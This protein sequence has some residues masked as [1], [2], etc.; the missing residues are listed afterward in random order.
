MPWGK[1]SLEFRLGWETGGEGVPRYAGQEQKRHAHLMK[2]SLSAWEEGDQWQSRVPP[3]SL[4][5][6]LISALLPSP[7]RVFPVGKDA[8]RNHF[9]H[10]WDTPRETVLVCLVSLLGNETLHTLQG[11]GETLK[12]GWWGIN[13]WR[14]KEEVLHKALILFKI[15]NQWLFYMCCSFKGP[16]LLKR[17]WRASFL[18]FLLYKPFL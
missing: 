4:W 17:H 5:F 3:S 6:C 18:H 8:H 16:Y 1:D 9:C 2:L 11:S 13:S 7:Q 12:L 10:S 14:G 15:M